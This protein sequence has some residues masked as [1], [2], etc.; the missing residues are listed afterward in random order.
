MDNKDKA[1]KKVRDIVDEICSFGCK[2]CCMTKNT[3]SCEKYLDEYTKRIFDTFIE[4]FN[5]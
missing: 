1:R 2:E 3:P 5:I 4:F